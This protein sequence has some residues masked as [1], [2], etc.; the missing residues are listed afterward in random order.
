MMAVTSPRASETGFQTAPLAWAG[1]AEE[2]I[3]K[4]SEV[5]NAVMNGKTNAAG[6]VTLTA[7]AATTTITDA[8]IGANTSVKLTPTTANAATAVATTYQTFPNAA[9]GAIVINHANNAQT[10]KT[11]AYVLLG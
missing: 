11:F 6:T 9:T 2:W 10:D 3:R 1:E 4:V 5:V 7:N 8:R